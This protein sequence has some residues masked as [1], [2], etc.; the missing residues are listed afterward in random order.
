MNACYLRCENY[1]S[2]IY[3]FYQQNGIK[4]FAPYKIHSKNEQYFTSNYDLGKFI[5]HFVGAGI[6]LAPPNGIFNLKHF[7]MI[8]VRYGYYLKNIGMKAQI[9][10]LNLKFK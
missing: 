8:E 1:F 9:V 3:R 2:R 4:Y 5:S 10:S 7:N 6:R